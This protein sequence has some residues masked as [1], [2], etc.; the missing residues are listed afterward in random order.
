MWPQT[1]RPR[2]WVPLLSSGHKTISTQV[3]HTSTNTIQRV[4]TLSGTGGLQEKSKTL[5]PLLQRSYHLTARGT[6]SALQV[7]HTA[8]NQGQV[9]IKQKYQALY[10]S[11]TKKQSQFLRQDFY[12]GQMARLLEILSCSVKFGYIRMC[13]PLCLTLLG[14]NFTAGIWRNCPG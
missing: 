4:S 1:T 6:F 13:Y 14:H 7:Y 10:R 5:Y 12:P 3:S 2:S 8:I 9:Y 11:T